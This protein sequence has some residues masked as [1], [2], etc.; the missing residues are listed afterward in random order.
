MS[1]TQ[2]SY[3]GYEFLWL[4]M[5]TSFFLARKWSTQKSGAD[6]GLIVGRVKHFFARCYGLVSA[7]DAVKRPDAAVARGTKTRCAARC[8]LFGPG[9][10]RRGRDTRSRRAR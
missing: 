10:C 5:M 1:R 6:Y 9:T 8:R 4:V 7:P 2:T 3:T